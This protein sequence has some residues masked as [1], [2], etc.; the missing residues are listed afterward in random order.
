[1]HTMMTEHDKEND[2]NQYSRKWQ[3]SFKHTRKYKN[4]DQIDK[5]N[6][7]RKWQK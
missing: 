3:K 5:D 2:L 4:N 6:G 7:E 1:M